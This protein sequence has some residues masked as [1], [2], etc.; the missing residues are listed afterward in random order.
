MGC[1]CRFRDA[2]CGRLQ[3]VRFRFEIPLCQP[4]SVGNLRPT[5]WEERRGLEPDS[6]SWSCL[7]AESLPAMP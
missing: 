2:L 7:I 5:A 4:P 6:L 3:V 1:F